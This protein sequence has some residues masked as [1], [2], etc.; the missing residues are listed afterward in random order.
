MRVGDQVYVQRSPSYALA[1]EERE[2]DARQSKL[3]PKAICPFT[4]SA[5]RDEMITVNKEQIRHSVSID[6]V[7]LVHPRGEQR[8]RSKL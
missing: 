1:P 7:T 3:L 6:C 5:V 2:Q 8:C 4:L